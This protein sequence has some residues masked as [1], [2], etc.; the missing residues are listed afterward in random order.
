MLTHLN[1]PRDVAARAKLNL[2][3]L[4]MA[5]ELCVSCAQI[6]NSSYG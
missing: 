6:E 2:D 5:P 3:N 4:W 1:I